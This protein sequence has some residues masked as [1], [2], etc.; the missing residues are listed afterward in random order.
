MSKILIEEDEPTQVQVLVGHTMIS[1]KSGSG[2]SNAC[3]WIATQYFEKGGY[4][5]VDLYDSG[6]FENM[7]YGFPEDDPFLID[8][9]TTKLKKTGF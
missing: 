5:I 3:E 6:R 1:G 9:Y 8:I 7:L 4:K 2:K